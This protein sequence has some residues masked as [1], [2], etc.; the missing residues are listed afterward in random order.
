M[1]CVD[2]KRIA[3]FISCVFA[4]VGDLIRTLHKLA[5]VRTLPLSCA[6]SPTGLQ[7]TPAETNITSLILRDQEAEGGGLKVQGL[8]YVAR[9]N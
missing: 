4:G 3:F 2:G 5:V 8:A 1:V 9:L 7:M 6:F